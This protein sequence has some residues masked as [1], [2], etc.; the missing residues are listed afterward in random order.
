MHNI[1]ILKEKYFIRQG[2]GVHGSRLTFYLLP[3][4]F[5]LPPFNLQFR[6]YL[7]RLLRTIKA[8][9]KAESFLKFNP[10]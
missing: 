7:P 3:S 10:G 8:V 9:I 1:T 4:T 2:S 5:Y 6:Q